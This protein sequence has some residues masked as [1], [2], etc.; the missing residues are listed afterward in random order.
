MRS[1]F[2][3]IVISLL[4]I[5]GFANEV[6]FGTKMILVKMNGKGISGTNFYLTMDQEKLSIFG[7]SG[8]NS[9][10]ISFQVKSNKTCIKTGQGRSEERRVG[11]EC[12]SRWSPYN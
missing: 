3:S 4:S 8:C 11:K 1:T 10:N 7:K 9:F 5:V 6:P 2:L 12:R